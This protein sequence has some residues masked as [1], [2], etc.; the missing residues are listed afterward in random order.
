MKAAEIMTCE[1]ITTS[2]ESPIEA[3]A[4]TMLQ[5][6]IS[7][8]PVVNADGKVV[9]IVTEGD[10]L[11]RAETGTEKF[12][13]RW[14][15]ALISGRRLA[16][17]YVRSHGRKVHQ[18]MT[19]GVVFV[20]PE[21]PLAEVVDLMESRRINRV[22]VLDNGRLVGIISRADLL[23]ALTQEFPNVQVDPVSDAEIRR[24]VLEEINRQRWTPPNNIDAKVE[25]GIVELRGIILSEPERLALCVLAENVPGVKSIR[26]RL[27]RFKPISGT[28]IDPPID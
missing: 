21:A 18:V 12:R 24:R 6:R 22:P 2:P 27:T 26:D 5:H 28:V 8:V 7:G 15:D 17:E 11:R 23:R 9:G 14:A 1:V 4:R 20:A 25:N 3:V 13:L 16:R 19:V 10:F